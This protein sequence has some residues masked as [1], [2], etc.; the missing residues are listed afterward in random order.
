M[1]FKKIIP[2]LIIFIVLAINFMFGFPRL[3]RFSAIDE[4]LWTYNRTPR[5]W[6]AVNDKKWSKTDINDKP[7]ITAV[8][9]S[10]LGLLSIDPLEYKSL[11]QEP[12]SDG[13]IGILKEINFHFR[14]PIYIFAL[15][16]API[17]YLLLK[18]LL[19]ETAAILSVIT[20]YL[21]PVILGISLII[22]PD[23][24]LWLFL[25]LS[26]ISFLLFQKSGQ[27]KYGY[28]SGLFLGLALLTKYVSAILYPFF[29]FFV[30]FEFIFSE[31]KF[32]ED[33]F[34]KFIVGYGKV[35]LA[36]FLTI[37]ILYPAVWANPEKLLEIT[38][39]SRPFRPFWPYFAG[40]LAL[41]LFDT[42][43]LKSIIFPSVLSPLK[44]YK[45]FILRSAGFF[46]LV[47]IFFVLLNTYAGMKVYDFDFMLSTPKPG[48]ITSF[49]PKILI[50]SVLA[51]IY[52]LIFSLVPLVFLFFIF[53]IFF[54]MRKNSDVA[55][56][57]TKII[58]YLLIFIVFY[59]LSSA[60]NHIEATVRYQIAIYPLA[61]IVASI[62]V[63][64]F[65]NWEKIK[66]YFPEICVFLFFIIVSAASL[67]LIKP[68]YFAYA[69]DFLPKR[70][71]LNPKD[72]GDG[73]F[74]AAEYLNSLP[75]AKNL[76]IWSDKVAVCESFAGKCITS[77]KNKNIDGV[78]FDY[79]VISH[80]RENKSAG[81][82]ITRRISDKKFLNFK[83]LYSSDEFSEHKIVIDERPNNFVKIIKAELIK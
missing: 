31:E 52:V 53:S 73:T 10:G 58:F 43:L 66:K 17:F 39:L 36:S 40:F 77:L 4:H 55:A 15:L 47:G 22:N 34:K 5:F 18:K 71:V 33:Y 50:G 42:F 26:I 7:G 23:S 6:K 30:F 62:G 11:I 57:E 13:Q 78:F 75:D 83:K 8:I 56:N 60:L 20:I 1:N 80:G 81:F 3:S 9:L 24:L 79:L 64:Q 48:G 76:T 35:V 25:P 69:S 63:Y 51:D 65:I 41:F 2:A 46:L 21:S 14:L 38:F 12:K 61:S 70:Y 82:A 37:A 44:K 74:E 27:D 32:D 29:L 45:K 72:M 19:N 54:N 16:M 49:A 59:Y 67:F 68:H 28:L